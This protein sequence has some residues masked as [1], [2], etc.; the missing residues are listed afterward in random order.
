MPGFLLDSAGYNLSSPE[1]QAQAIQDIIDLQNKNY[2]RAQSITGYQVVAYQQLTI[3]LING[4]P[5]GVYTTQYIHGLGYPPRVIA[6]M[7]QP[8]TQFYAPLPYLEVQFDG[9]VGRMN[10]NQ[11]F[12]VDE[13][14]LYFNVHAINRGGFFTSTQFSAAF[15]IFNLPLNI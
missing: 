4:Q 1:G 9:G 10:T 7:L 12:T 8:S 3:S 13:Q 2:D 6:F 5:S 14:N 11:Y 15:Y